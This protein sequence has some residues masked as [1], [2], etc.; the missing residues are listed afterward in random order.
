MNLKLYCERAWGDKHSC[1]FDSCKQVY[2]SDFVLQLKNVIDQIKPTPASRH[3]NKSFFVHKE[4]NSCSHL[5]VRTDAVKAS[6]QLPYEG[7]FKVVH[8]SEG[9]FTIIKKDRECNIS[10][11]RLKP[12]FI[13][14][15]SDE[16]EGSCNNETNLCNA[17]GNQDTVENSSYSNNTPKVKKH[18]VSFQA[19]VKSHITRAGRETK[20]PAKLR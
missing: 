1:V 19:L 11:N 13:E 12:C 18:S 4:L 5:F 8:R 14:I 20:L 2:Q 10:I 7:P 16:D 9:Y 3:G 6:L 15:K 17:N